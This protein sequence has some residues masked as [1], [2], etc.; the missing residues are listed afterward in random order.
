[1]ASKFLRQLHF[2]LS[3]SNFS[4]ILKMITRC[5]ITHHL[6]FIL[7]FVLY[8]LYSIENVILSV[9]VYRDDKIWLEHGVTPVCDWWL[10]DCLTS[11]RSSERTSH[12]QRASRRQHFTV[13]R[14]ILLKCNKYYIIYFTRL[15]GNNCLNFTF[16][17]R[18]KSTISNFFTLNVWFY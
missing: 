1:M 13:T 7:Y 15:T 3:K 16:Y 4:G 12:A 9:A 11:N 14:F 6:F 8:F 18:N 10:N 2:F 17:G 5:V